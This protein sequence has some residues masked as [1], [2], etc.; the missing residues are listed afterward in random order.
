[1]TISKTAFERW[2]LSHSYDIAPAEFPSEI[3]QYADGQT[4]AAFLAWTAGVAS[5]APTATKTIP[6]PETFIERILSFTI[7]NPKPGR[8]AEISGIQT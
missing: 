6:E 8:G 4:Q 2:A 1:M 3:R 5:V 7:R